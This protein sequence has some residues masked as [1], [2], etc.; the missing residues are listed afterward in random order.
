MSIH[1]LY[2]SPNANLYVFKQLSKLFFVACTVKRIIHKYTL[3]IH[4]ND[5]AMY[6]LYYYCSCTH[7]ILLFYRDASVPYSRTCRRDSQGTLCIRH[8]TDVP[9]CKFMCCSP[10]HSWC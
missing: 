7:S 4:A 1:S 2:L 10:M 3:I 5:D 9:I 8:L 6:T